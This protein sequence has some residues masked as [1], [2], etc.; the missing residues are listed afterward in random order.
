MRLTATLM[1]GREISGI[2]T[3]ARILAS[4]PTVIEIRETIS[5]RVVWTRESK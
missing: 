1:N 5:G 2:C 3:V 4:D